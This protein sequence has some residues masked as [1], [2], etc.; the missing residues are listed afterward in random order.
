MARV[1]RQVSGTS[2][3]Y[4]QILVDH[5]ENPKNV[6]SRNDPDVGTGLLGV[7]ACGDVLKF[8]IRKNSL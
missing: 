5:F 2:S 1:I 4:H 3:G 6:G 8:Q 7:P